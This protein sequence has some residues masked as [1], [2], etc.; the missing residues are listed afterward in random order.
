VLR[1]SGVG[2]GRV[3]WSEN[4]KFRLLDFTGYSFPERAAGLNRLGFIR[5]LTR[6]GTDPMESIYFGFMTA[7]PEETAA[8]ARKAL[9][10]ETHD[11]L[12]TA[13]A[14][15]IAPGEM[16]T[17]TSHFTAPPRLSL[18]QREELLAMAHEALSAA[19]PKPCEF[20][21]RTS[22]QPTFLQ[23]LATLLQDSSRDH[24]QCVFNA[25]VYDLCLRRYPDAN[26]TRYFRGKRL[27]AQASTVIR[28]EGRLRHETGGKETNFQVWVEEGARPLPLRIEYQP[29]S[30]LRLTFEVDEG[31]VATGHAAD[32]SF[33]R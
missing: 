33:E 16:E 10:K 11:Q 21:P 22:S 26:A 18:A 8:D 31:P 23:A 7:S 1:R 24:T 9:H 13:I 2:A 30:Y 4:A 15:R 32:A 29:K 5:E 6:K 25:R 27:I 14:G 28:A 12:Y 19:S 17:I 3:T 20:D